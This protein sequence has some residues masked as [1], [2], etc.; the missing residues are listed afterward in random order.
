MLQ[1]TDTLDRNS[2]Q[3]WSSGSNSLNDDSDR[4]KKSDSL[5]DSRKQNTNAQTFQLPTR[6]ASWTSTPDLGQI[7]DDTQASIPT[8][9]IT[10]PRKRI[11]APVKLDTGQKTGK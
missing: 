8:F 3:S 1:H 6:P 7:N 10:L 11:T 9:H 2:R 4:Y 5:Y